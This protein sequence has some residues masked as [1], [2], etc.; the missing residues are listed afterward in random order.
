[1]S[2]CVR[3]LAL[4]SCL[5]VFPTNTLAQVGSRIECPPR[6]E[7]QLL[8]PL[9]DGGA[10]ALVYYPD[11]GPG[12]RITV[13]VPVAAPLM[14]VRR[15]LLEAERWPEFIPALRTVTLLSR[16]G[17]RTAYRFEV[18]ASLL[19]MSAVTTLTDVNE[20]R[21]DFT[22]QESDF[23]VAAARWD[24]LDDGPGRTLLVTTNWSD[25][26]QGHWLLR[27]TARSNL[28]ATAGMN[29]AVDLILALSV[30]RRALDLAGVP[31]PPRPL[32]GVVS[33]TS[34][35]PPPRGPW[36]SLVNDPKRYY[37]FAF[38]LTEDGAVS[39]MSVMHH[40]WGRADALEAR[41]VEIAG[42]G[43]HLPGVRATPINGATDR[44]EIVVS[45][46]LDSASG[47]LIQRR[48]A[49]G[50]ILLE[51][52]GGAL[53]GAHWRWDITRTEGRGTLLTLTGNVHESMASTLVRA[54]AGREPYLY[55]GVA[56]LRELMWM[57]YMLAGI[58]F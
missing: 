13:I 36:E 16:H 45:T 12:A 9:A 21:V 50:A 6:D 38:R 3:V 31:T 35:T 19:D 5:L 30:G 57:R 18:S 11:A 42:Y 10:A 41:L 22:V 27:R 34:L 32:H 29:V 33:P 40:T 25:P 24:L 56:A 46:P 26:S 17:R 48:D 15:A 43:N 55:A 7:L 58:P 44:A 4:L 47:T 39:Q 2:V 28:T 53:E 20:R 14:A 1:M 8:R 23:G 49:S 52:H 37:L 54:A 51:G